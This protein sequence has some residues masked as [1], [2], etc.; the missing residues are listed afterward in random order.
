MDN[1]LLLSYS[2]KMSDMWSDKFSVF[3]QASAQC[4][5]ARRAFDGGSD[6]AK[7]FVRLVRK[8][9]GSLPPDLNFLHGDFRLPGGG[10]SLRMHC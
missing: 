2:Y 6:P 8:R 7:L 9:V 4:A 5:L 10:K 3:R 1:G